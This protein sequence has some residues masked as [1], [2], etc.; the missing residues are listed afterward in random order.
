MLFQPDVIQFHS[1]LHSIS[2]D[3]E[4]NNTHDQRGYNNK[5]NE[6]VSINGVTKN[7]STCTSLQ[8]FKQVICH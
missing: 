8:R 2:E 4:L 5:I 3:C 7:L 6:L 1:N